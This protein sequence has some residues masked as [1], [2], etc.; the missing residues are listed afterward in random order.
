MAKAHLD[1]FKSVGSGLWK[2][3]LGQGCVNGLIRAVLDSV[4]PIC[5]RFDSG[6]VLDSVG[7]GL[8]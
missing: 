6:L 2:I 8:D 7:P 5:A 4:A 1:Q 3:R